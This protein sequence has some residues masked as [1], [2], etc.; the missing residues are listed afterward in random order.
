MPECLNALH[1]R[2]LEIEVVLGIQLVLS[3]LVRFF[4]VVVFFLF[5]LINSKSV[6]TREGKPLS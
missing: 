4:L 3:N 2:C 1:V 6:P 5:L